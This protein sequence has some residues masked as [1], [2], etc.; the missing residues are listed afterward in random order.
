MC[1]YQKPVGPPDPFE[2]YQIEGAAEKQKR[3]ERPDES[4]A[5][6]SEGGIKA[7]LINALQKALDY[8]VKRYGSADPLELEQIKTVLVL[9]EFFEILKTGF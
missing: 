9:K 5:P 2:K 4:R 3:E 1:S 6:P 7:Y 8:V